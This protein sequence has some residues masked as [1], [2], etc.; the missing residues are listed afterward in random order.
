MYKYDNHVERQLICD[1]ILG[2]TE[3]PDKILTEIK[4][5]LNIEPV[6]EHNLHKKLTSLNINKRYI[7]DIVDNIFKYPESKNLIKYINNEL[8]LEYFKG[9]DIVNIIDI[10]NS[11]YNINKDLLKWLLKYKWS[12]TP[13]LG[14]GEVF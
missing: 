14:A 13:A 12:A 7:K 8:N 3:I 9:N 11:K 6:L 4:S 10:L 2:D 5:L 1:K